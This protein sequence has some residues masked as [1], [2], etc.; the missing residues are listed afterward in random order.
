[1]PKKKVSQMTKSEIQ[2]LRDAAFK[3]LE[4]ATAQSLSHKG[5]SASNF[6]LPALREDLAYWDR[7]LSLA[8]GQPKY[9]VARF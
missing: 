6:D 8:N 3:R 9:S 7:Q 1:V 4:A 5:R 2:V